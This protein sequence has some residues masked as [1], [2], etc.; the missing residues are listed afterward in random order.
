MAEH[1]PTHFKLRYTSAFQDFRCRTLVKSF[2]GKALSKKWIERKVV[3]VYV[4]YLLTIKAAG[5]TL[6]AGL[7][8]LVD[9]SLSS[10]IGEL[11]Y[12]ALTLKRYYRAISTFID[13]TKAMLFL[14]DRFY[15][16]GCF[17]QNGGIYYLFDNITAICCSIQVRKTNWK[18][19][20]IND[21]CFLNIQNNF[22]FVL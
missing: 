10:P 3:A 4:T 17:F 5:F 7:S 1:I 20:C 13:H 22:P 16:C 14:L 11:S 9:P 6:E 19:L 18:S 8:T 15:I 2:E 21:G 12:A